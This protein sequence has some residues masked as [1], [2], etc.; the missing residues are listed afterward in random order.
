MMEGSFRWLFLFGLA[1]VAACAQGQENTPDA[2]QAAKIEKDHAILGRYEATGEEK[3]CISLTRISQSHVLSD[4]EIFFE[5]RGREG[6]LSNLPNRCPQLGF[7]ESF[8]YST[9]TGQLCNTDII[10]VLNR[11]SVAGA[12]CGL[13]KFVAYKLKEKE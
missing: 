7:Y 8:T 2:A 4:T 11:S 5:M 12:S 6:Y 10:T 1:A 9:S 3:S 13:G